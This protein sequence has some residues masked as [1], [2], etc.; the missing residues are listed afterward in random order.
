[1]LGLGDLSQLG[2]ILNAL[3]L[4]VGIAWVFATIAVLYIP[5]RVMAAAPSI[6]IGARIGISALILL[7]WLGLTWTVLYAQGSFV[8]SMAF[9][10]M[11]MLLSTLGP[12]GLCCIILGLFR[13]GWFLFHTPKPQ[14]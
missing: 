13:A 9:V 2:R 12:I 7:M 11:A 4:V 10:I 8:Y 3:G 5:Q 14:G 1:M 6:G